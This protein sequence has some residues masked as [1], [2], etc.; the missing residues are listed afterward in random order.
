MIGAMS[1]AY[2]DILCVLASRVNDLLGDIAQD[3]YAHCYVA[4]G[5][6]AC[7]RDILPENSSREAGLWCGVL[8]LTDTGLA[9]RQDVHTRICN[10]SHK[11][12]PWR[13]SKE[14]DLRDSPYTS[15]RIPEEKT[16]ALN[17]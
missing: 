10:P 5:S 9:Y 13:G 17:Y 15:S 6:A 3:A 11:Q 16:H 7:G 4:T 8:K 2:C 12:L 1:L 14:A